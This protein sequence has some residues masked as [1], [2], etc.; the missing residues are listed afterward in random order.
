MDR[1]IKTIPTGGVFFIRNINT[2]SGKYYENAIKN[3][4]ILL[5]YKKTVYF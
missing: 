4:F 3:L 5:I 2:S 1:K